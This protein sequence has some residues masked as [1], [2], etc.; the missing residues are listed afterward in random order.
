MHIQLGGVTMLALL[1]SGST[2]NFIF[3]E[4]AWGTSL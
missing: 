1:D 4:A 2:H 3:K